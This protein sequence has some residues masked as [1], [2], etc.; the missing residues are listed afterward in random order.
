MTDNPT[1]RLREQGAYA[2]RRLLL[3]WNPT[4]HTR[5]P[6]GPDTLASM[7]EVGIWA[8][9]VELLEHAAKTPPRLTGEAALGW[10]AGME[11]AGAALRQ[12]MESQAGSLPPPHPPRP[13]WT[14]P[15][16]LSRRDGESA[17][18]YRPGDRIDWGAD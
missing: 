2:R 15:P 6:E 10:R 3:S 11:A 16:S 17:V 1:R 9:A 5:T 8:R 7:V 14:P 4:G 13:R 18:L 12:A